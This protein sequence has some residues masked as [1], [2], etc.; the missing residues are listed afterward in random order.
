MEW[1]IWSVQANTEVKTID[2]WWMK[3][4]LSVVLKSSCYASNKCAALL[5][6]QD[7]KLM[8][9][10]YVWFSPIAFLLRIW[11][12]SFYCR[13]WIKWTTLPRL[14]MIILKSSQGLNTFCKTKKIPW[15]TMQIHILSCCLGIF[16]QILEKGF[17]HC[18][19]HLV[20]I[21]S[22]IAKFCNISCCIYGFS[23]HV[24]N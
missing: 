12:V 21:G 6:F 14:I 17:K 16:A 8:F 13:H 2:V 1:L 5:F 11:L 23:L 19:A 10:F 7:E 20:Q 24:Q 15:W 22:S 4:P 18:H 3:P 9:E